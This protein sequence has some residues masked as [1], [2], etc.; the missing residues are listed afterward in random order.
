[1][2]WF[3]DGQIRRYLTQMIR[4]LSNFYYR[5]GNGTLVQVPVMYGDMTRQVANIIKENSENKL[6]SVPRIALYITN[7]ELDRER[8]SD[9]S[10][11]GKTTVRERAYDEVTQKYLDKQGKNYT[12]ERIM[13]TPY[14]LTV[15]ADI[16]SSNTDQK[17][18]IF[19]QIS[20]LFTPSIEIQTTDNFV[21]WTSLTVVNLDSTNFSSRT[22][23]VGT[24][25]EID[26]LTL[27]MSTPIWISPPA[28]VKKMGIITNIITSIF[29]EEKGTIDL[30]LSMPELTPYDT[31]T[32]GRFDK[33]NGTA[34]E[35]LYDSQ[36]VATNYQQFGVFVKNKTARLVTNNSSI[37]ENWWEILTV[38][39]GTYEP[40]A[41]KI[42]L[43]RT[44]LDI[45][46][47]GT[48][49]FN[50]I[51][52]SILNVTWDA[53]TFP[54]DTI[55]EGRTSID[56]VIDPKRFNPASVKNTGVRLLLTEAVGD[57]EAANG[58]TA[59][60]QPNGSDFY[61]SAND[62]IEWTGSNWRVVFNSQEPVLEKV[63]VTN[64][65]TKI[66]YVW[67][68]I[69]WTESINGYYPPG[70]WRIELE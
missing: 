41:S 51:N 50:A 1:M 68:G 13:P 40:N 26:V 16:W 23:P 55:I 36:V 67:N 35:T 27:T 46:I 34:T 7:I 11:V 59:W 32:A 22:I 42:F 53:D 31:S 47:V 14:K 57:P 39:P 25:S 65:N 48:F 56:Y 61:A 10:F 45:S 66:Q 18:Q 29:N 8:L 9:P 12:I 60:K 64:L 44:D 38:F 4:M 63:F 5:T 6:P 24:E 69:E 33:D 3:Y 30:G 20:V 15:N 2:L 54:T 70:S 37:K 49:V 58:P 21:D 17:L 62:I 43:N 28:K 52:N 19:E